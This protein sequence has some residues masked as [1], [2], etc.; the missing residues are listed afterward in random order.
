MARVKFLDWISDRP[1]LK[2]LLYMALVSLGIVIVAFFLVRLYG[3]HGKEL[4]LQNIV[5]ENIEVAEQSYRDLRF[6]AIDSLYQDGQ[7]GGVIIKQDPLPGTK[8]KPG[9][10]IY[11]TITSYSRED[12][13]M[14]KLSNT[15]SSAIKQLERLGMMGNLIFRVDPTCA[16]AVIRKTINGCRVEEGEKLKAGTMVDLTI[17]M[18]DGDSQVLPFVI[19]MNSNEARQALHSKMFN[20]GEEHG[21]RDRNKAIVVRTEPEFTGVNKYPY[22]TAVEIWYKSSDKVDPEQ[23]KQDFRVDSS[24]IIREEPAETEVEFEDEG[25]NDGVIW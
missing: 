25:L 17:A 14:P 7:P 12:M 2:N 23:L 16:G 1:V 24:K 6:I 19:G 18:R 9:R 4:E 5:G 11:V 8:V 13:M 15:A 22:G 21:L 10:K 20:V 3:R